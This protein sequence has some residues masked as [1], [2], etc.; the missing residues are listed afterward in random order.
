MGLEY[1]EK[2]V[3]IYGASGSIWDLQTSSSIFKDVTYDLTTA[4]GWLRLKWRINTAEPPAKQKMI[5]PNDEETLMKR[6][7]FSHAQ[8]E[9]KGWW[10]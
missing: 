3:L 2:N 4:V 7:Q 5:A 1:V 8:G 10:R 6:H 9:N